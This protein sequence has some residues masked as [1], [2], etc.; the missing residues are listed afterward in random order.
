MQ[1]MAPG[2]SSEPHAGHLFDAGAGVG[3]GAGG[4]LGTW[5]GLL[6]AGGAL[7]LGGGGGVG[8]A[9]TAAAT[10]SRVV[11]GTVKTVLQ[12]GQRNCLPAELSPTC[13]AVLQ[14]EQLM[15]CGMVVLVW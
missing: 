13:M 1:A 14:W 15:I 2:S 9:A 4:G 3:G 12:V 10:G 7:T 6:G 5:A 11:A 8:A